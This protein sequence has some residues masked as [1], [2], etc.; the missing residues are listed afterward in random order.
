MFDVLYRDPKLSPAVGRALD[1]KGSRR[2]IRMTV[3]CAI[4]RAVQ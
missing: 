2:L 1:D 4:R 3:D